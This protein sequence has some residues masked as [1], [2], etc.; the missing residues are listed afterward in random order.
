MTLPRNNSLTRR[1]LDTRMATT[2]L[3]FDGYYIS[4]QLGI[5]RGICVRSRSVFG[6][7]G[8][9]FQ[10]VF[11]GDITILTALCERV[12]TEAFDIMIAHADRLGA[13]AVIG[14][15][16]DATEVM[17]GVSEVLCYGTAVIAEPLP[18]EHA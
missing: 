16:Y 5:V 2:A 10:M 4:E 18:D 12:R 17:R 14:V 13:N 9:K 11:G 3:G 6:L 7:V 1:G 8:A 15:R